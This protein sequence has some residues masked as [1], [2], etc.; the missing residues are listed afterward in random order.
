M[1]Q[2]LTSQEGKTLARHLAPSLP[3]FQRCRDGRQEST[4]LKP[5]TPLCLWPRV[6]VLVERR[7][8]HCRGVAK[9]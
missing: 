1:I 2:G 5:K 7:G 6:K 9:V 3:P 4:E 8:F